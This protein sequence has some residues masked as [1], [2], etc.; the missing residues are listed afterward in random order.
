VLLDGVDLPGRSGLAAT[1]YRRGAAGNPAVQPDHSRTVALANPAL[2]RAHVIQ[3]ARLAG[4]DEFVA[5]LPRGYDTMIEER[6][7]NLVAASAS[8]SP[9][10]ARSSPIRRS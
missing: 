1:A 6:G 9:S 8:V 2:P 7:A 4:A 10:R 5:K 3:M